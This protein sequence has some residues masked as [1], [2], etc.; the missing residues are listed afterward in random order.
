MSFNANDYK[1]ESTEFTPID[2]LEP[3]GYPGRLIHLFNIGLQKQNPYKGEEKP[4]KHEFW[5]TYELPDEFLKDE[6]GN[7]DKTKPYW[8]SERFS[9]NPLSSENA[10]ST[11][12]YLALD[13]ENVHD[14]DW[15]ALLGTPA[16]INIVQ[17]RSKKDPNKI[18]MNIRSVQTMR[19]KDAARTPDL[20]N[21]VK[22]FDFYNPDID[23]FLSIPPFI[24]KIIKESLDFEGSKLEKLLSELGD[25]EE[26]PKEKKKPAKSVPVKEVIEDDEDDWDE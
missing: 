2:P 20:I 16:M 12:R 19:P 4:P 13:P 5:V 7:E 10:K 18:Y 24:Q 1:S 14:G 22:L 9:I 3:G 6:D 15:S 8:V 21:E 17:N 25:K 26:T 11:A 23:V